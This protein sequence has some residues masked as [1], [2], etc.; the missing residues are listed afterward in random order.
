M[1]DQFNRRIIIRSS[2]YITDKNDLKVG[3]STQQI[4]I[5]MHAEAYLMLSV[6]NEQAEDFHGN[7]SAIKG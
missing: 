3:V 2:N 1:Q 4:L 6:G 7:V 5:T